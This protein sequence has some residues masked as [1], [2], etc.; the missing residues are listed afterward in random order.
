M[1][2]INRNLSL[3]TLQ[4]LVERTMLNNLNYFPDNSYQEQ[5]KALDI[6]KKKLF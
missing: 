3:N 2:H 6:F 5:Q 4:E 1:V